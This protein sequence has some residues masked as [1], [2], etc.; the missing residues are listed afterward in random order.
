MCQILGMNCASPT[1]FSFSLKGFCRRGG[2]TD[3]HAHGWGAAIYMGQ[4]LQTFK[5]TQPACRSPLAHFV[6]H[7]ANQMKTFVSEHSEETNWGF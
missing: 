3:K 5:D 7:P 6:L 4:A 1:D 2:E